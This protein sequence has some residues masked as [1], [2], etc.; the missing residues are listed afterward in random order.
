[1]PHFPS[2]S[3]IIVKN[4][5]TES[6]QV[7]DI[8]NT[9]QSKLNSSILTTTTD[10]HAHAFVDDSNLMS[11]EGSEIQGINRIKELY[12]KRKETTL[13]SKTLTSE[14]SYGKP[15]RQV[16]VKNVIVDTESSCAT[17]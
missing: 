2:Q 12:F 14:I 5:N 8:R 11:P 1:M 13:L 4:L 15:I 10:H 16:E 3:P 9:V 7:M 17:L 6:T